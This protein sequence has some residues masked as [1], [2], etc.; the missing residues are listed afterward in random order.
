MF[1]ESIY[2]GSVRR[3]ENE[4]E[5]FKEKQ[6]VLLFFAFAPK[7]QTRNHIQSNQ[8][9]TLSYIP[10]VLIQVT[11]HLLILLP[12]KQAHKEQNNNKKNNIMTNLSPQEM[13]IV[14]ITL[15]P[16]VAIT[17]IALS[18]LLYEYHNGFLVTLGNM[19]SGG[20]LL[21]GALVHMLPEATSLVDALRNKG[22][23][24]V[25]TFPL[26]YSLFGGCFLLL[27]CVET[28]VERYVDR[29]VTNNPNDRTQQGDLPD[30]GKMAK[31]K[32]RSRTFLESEEEQLPADHSSSGGSSSSSCHEVS[33][34]EPDEEQPPLNVAPPTNSSGWVASLD[35][36]AKHASTTITWD[37]TIRHRP[38]VMVV[39][40]SHST[41][42]EDIQTV[43][44]WVSILLTVVL[45]IHVL[46]EGMALGSAHETQ[47]ILSGVIVIGC[48][49]I[50]A[51]FALG[52]SLMV[53]GYWNKDRQGGRR[54]FF[55]L[56]A[57]F[58]ILTIV[59]IAIGIAIGKADTTDHSSESL[60]TAFL[61][62][63]VGGSFLFVA[64]VEVIPGELD[65]I[66]QYQMALPPVFLALF[67]GFILMSVLAKWV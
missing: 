66:R 38:K 55:V 62:C 47:T 31:K 41:A 56:S 65:K 58:V 63:L 4:N 11:K 34:S 40:H 39:P 24:I 57:V 50:F 61:V 25:G 60:T 44:P 37:T 21:S 5:D 1:G 19:F 51:A 17:G 43:N 16:S 18:V 42:V 59:G 8:Q 3:D 53:S 64:T 46:I 7:D 35:D 27:L 29:T 67:L 54:M 10:G 12:R 23:S 33:P 36:D 2:F 26:T 30:Q 15:L 49:K 32:K 48:H 22:H 20:V 6:L 13:Q 9:I 28:Y 45:S 52:S 14:A